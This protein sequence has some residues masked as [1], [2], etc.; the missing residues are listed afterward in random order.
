MKAHQVIAIPNWQPFASYA[1]WQLQI[2][3]WE[4][5]QNFDIRH[6]EEI[7]DFKKIVWMHADEVIRLL[8]IEKTSPVDLK[9]PHESSGSSGW[10][11]CGEI[12]RRIR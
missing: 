8:T 12:P 5:R 11:P 9:Q 7:I 3:Q 10:S 1:H 4:S 6:E 2:V